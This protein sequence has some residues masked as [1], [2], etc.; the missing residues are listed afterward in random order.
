MW[1]CWTKMVLFSQVLFVHVRLIC[2]CSSDLMYF[3][4]RVLYRCSFCSSVSFM[5]CSVSSIFCL[6][7]FLLLVILF[8]FCVLFCIYSFCSSVS[9]SLLC[10]VVCYVVFY[11]IHVLSVCSVLSFSVFCAVSHSLFTLAVSIYI[12]CIL[13]SEE[14]FV[15][16]KGE[17]EM[18]SELSK[19]QTK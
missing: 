19:L 18:V 12:L 13:L 11:L 15:L 1:I 7:H 6:S 16:C 2:V 17:A 8:I 9:C 5:L 4:C 14:M 10:S 3:L